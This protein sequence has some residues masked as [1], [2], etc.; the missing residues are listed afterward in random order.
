M[1]DV[2]VLYPLSPA[3]S[4][5]SLLSA[6]YR[7]RTMIEFFLYM[8]NL[9]GN[10]LSC[11]LE[12]IDCSIIPVSMGPFKKNRWP[13]APLAQISEARNATTIYTPIEVALFYKYS[14]VT[15]A[16]PT[17]RIFPPMPLF[18]SH[19]VT[20]VR[21]IKSVVYT[22]KRIS[23]TT[24]CSVWFETESG[25]QI[26]QAGTFSLSD[27]LFIYSRYFLYTE[28]SRCCLSISTK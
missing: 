18:T 7:I 17:I 13:I 14:F 2:A 10:T 20:H 23:M 22:S 19:I 15:L 24:W 3:R 9:C 27:R 8:N 4:N 21:T 6:R 12:Y 28:P 25:F 1:S 26:K 5:L 16:A 11:Q